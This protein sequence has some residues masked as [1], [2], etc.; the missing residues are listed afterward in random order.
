MSTKPSP[1]GHPDPSHQT[2]VFVSYTPTSPLPQP[3]VT[4]HVSQISE[5]KWLALGADT[6]VSFTGSE[7]RHEV[8]LKATPVGTIG[9]TFSC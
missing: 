3:H 5:T 9:E 8:S 4:S 1:P 6:Y 2:A 7:F